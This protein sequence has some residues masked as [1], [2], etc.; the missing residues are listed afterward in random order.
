MLIYYTQH[1]IYTKKFFKENTINTNSRIFF[2]HSDVPSHKMTSGMQTL[3]YYPL[4]QD[5]S[6]APKGYGSG[7]RSLASHKYLE[8]IVLASQ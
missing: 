5:F 1:E 6:V 7:A 3:N 2:L 4:Q 8:C